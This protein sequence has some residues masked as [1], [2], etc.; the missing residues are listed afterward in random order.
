[1][2]AACSES[3]APRPPLVFSVLSAGNG[4]ACG[5]T[6]DG[7]AYCWGFNEDGGLGNGTTGG[8]STT[9]VAVSAP[10]GVSFSALSAGTAHSCGLTASHTAYCWGENESGQLGIGLKTDTARPVPVTGSVPFLGVRAASQLAGAGFT[11]GVTTGG[12]G[13]C[14]GSNVNGQLGDGT[15]TPRA[16]PVRVAGQQ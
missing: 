1:M 14:W 15:T 7:A 12:V 10:P 6:T 3:T 5:L 2:L 8:I 16:M 4:H 9:P 13:Y 11:C